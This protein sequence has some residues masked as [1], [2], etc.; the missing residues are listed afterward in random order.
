MAERFV[1]EFAGGFAGYWVHAT[2][3]HEDKPTAS[4]LWFALAPGRV[5]DRTE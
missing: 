4:V 3:A 5:V 1:P 2:N